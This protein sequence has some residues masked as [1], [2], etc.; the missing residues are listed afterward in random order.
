VNGYACTE[1]DWYW[2]WAMGDRVTVVKEH[3]LA[4]L[5]AAK[6]LARRAEIF[7]TSSKDYSRPALQATEQATLTGAWL[8]YE[9]REAQMHES[10]TEPAS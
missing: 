4:H 2:G 1:C 3:Q 6:L 7:N 9:A 5:I 10:A 8:N